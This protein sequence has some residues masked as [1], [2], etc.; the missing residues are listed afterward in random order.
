MK[1]IGHTGSDYRNKL[2][3]GEAIELSW[4]LT[5]VEMPV[6]ETERLMIRPFTLGDLDDIHRILD[7]ELANVEFGNEGAMTRAA[8]QEW[9]EWCV[10]NYRQL[11]ALYQPPYGDRA[12]ALK[13]GTTVIG[14]VGFVPSFGP[15]GQLPARGVRPSRN[16]AEFGLYYAI[17]PAFQRQGYATE[18]VQA[19]VQYAFTMLN[20]E[21]IVATTQYDNAASM[22][23][24]RRLGMQI[25]KNPFPAPPWFQVVGILENKRA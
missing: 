1:G 20:V 11:A 15:F 8:R 5:V 25:E 17:S 21:R 23:V 6:L 22:G 3:L 13:V 14:A 7:I 12:I 19:M 24:M 4:R 2:R 10:R 9:L 16:T 18:A